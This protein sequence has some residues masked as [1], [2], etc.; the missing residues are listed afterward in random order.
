LFEQKPCT[1]KFSAD[2]LAWDYFDAD[3]CINPLMSKL[4]PQSNGPYSK[5]GI[6]TLAVDGWVKVQ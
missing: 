4:K 3:M 1:R 2:G 5:N 6:G